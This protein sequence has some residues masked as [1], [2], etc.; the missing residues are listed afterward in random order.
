MAIAAPSTTTGSQAKLALVIGVGNYAGNKKLKNPENDVDDMS[1]M[2]RN[3]GFTVTTAVNL[4]HAEMD[5]HI[6]AFKHK[7]RKGDLVLFYF[8][9][10]GKQW[11]VCTEGFFNPDSLSYPNEIFFFQ[12]C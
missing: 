4:T 12:Y 10:H 9:G 11:E 5:A 2:L 6:A 7:I 8:A 1:R 3:I